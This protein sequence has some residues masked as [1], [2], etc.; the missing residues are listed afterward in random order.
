MLREKTSR[1]S[2]AHAPQPRDLAVLV[3][4][5]VLQDGKLDVLVLV[6]DLLG[7]RVRLLLTFLTT[8]AQSQYQMER[9]LLLDVVVRQ[10]AAILQLLSRKN[11]TLL[12][13]NN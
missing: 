1:S 11:K 10:R 8:S 7:R 4:L 2:W 5:V 12:W 13:A 3:D 6:L 9:G